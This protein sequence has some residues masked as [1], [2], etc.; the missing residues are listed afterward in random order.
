MDHISPRQANS[1][2]LL[3]VTRGL[4]VL[5]AFAIGYPTF[6]QDA[7]AGFGKIDESVTVGVVPGKMAYD[8]PSFSVKPNSNVKL[9]LKN[10]DI[11]QHNLVI[12][13]PSNDAGLSVAQK[14]WAM[15]DDALKK[16]F[17]PDSPDV[18]DHVNL[19]DPGKSNTI[20]FKAPAAEGE[21]PFVCTV[22]GH[23]MTMKGFMKVTAHRDAQQTAS[24]KDVKFRY[25]D[26]KLDDLPNPD[27]IKPTKEGAIKNNLFSIGV[28]N[29]R[30]IFDYVFD[31]TFV[32]P[33]TAEYTFG[34]TAVQKGDL[35][36]DGNLVV[37]S[38]LAEKTGKI[39]LNK[40]DHAMR[41]RFYSTSSEPDL[42]L[43]VSAPDVRRKV[44]TERL[45]RPD[46]VEV[47]DAP[48]I[49]RVLLPNTSPV[50]MA[51]G[52]VGGLNYCFDLRQCAVRYVWTGSFLDVGPNRDARGGK[53]CNP[54]GETF[55][56]GYDGF[57]LRI[58]TNDKP[59]VKFLGY[60]MQASPQIMFTVD[61]TKVTE[62]VAAAPG[63]PLEAHRVT[64]SFQM[65][66][67]PGP[68]RFVTTSGANKAV[69]SAGSFDG[70]VLTVP[71]DKASKFSVTLAATTHP[72]EKP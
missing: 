69:S 33:V 43:Y 13:K 55:T 19:V 20:Y 64:L 4:F 23:A 59:V 2:F 6:A 3:R 42:A 60:R 68:V 21:Y 24:L 18:L 72:T 7:P 45:A 40:G 5:M 66:N 63:T 1:P 8:T 54:L 61:G 26:T 65:D 29:P 46:V 38:S 53:T 17:I 71:A 12:C 67:P 32:A 50:S 34:L 48:R 14:A 62:T 51:V 28:A 56:L 44:L 25:Y 31:A 27:A 52:L 11:M 57:P 16:Q 10:P 35:T 49:V 36:M 22:P 47:T 30:G 15:G 41:L 39:K 58:G 9:T 37:T 70:N